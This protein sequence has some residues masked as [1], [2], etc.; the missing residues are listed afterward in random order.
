MVFKSCLAT[1]SRFHRPEET[2]CIAGYSAAKGANLDLPHPDGV[3]FLGHVY[4]LKNEYARSRLFIAPTRFA[5]GVPFKVH[6]AFSYGLPVVGSKLIN[7]Q[8]T[9]N[10]DSGGLV[11]ASVQ[12]DG[13][14][15]AG[16]CLELLTDDELWV[17]NVTRP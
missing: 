8:I 13:Q 3:T 9:C 1:N 7:E 6:E 10:G 16:S 2:L 5:A 12:D 14:Q 11:A 4:D 15:F 17:R